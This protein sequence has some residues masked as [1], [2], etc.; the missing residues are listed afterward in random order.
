MNDQ[1]DFGAAADKMVELYSQA[2]GGKQK[3]RYRIAVK[4]VRQLTGRRR[5][6]EDDVTTLTRELLERGFVLVDMD[7]FF[8]VMAANTFLNYRRVNESCVV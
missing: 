1:T 8:V 6:Y 3:G 5:L 7:S 4:L 2:F